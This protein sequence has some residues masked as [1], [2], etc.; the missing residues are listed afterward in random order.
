MTLEK[1]RT[2]VGS[3]FV[4]LSSIKKTLLLSVLV[5]EFWTSRLGHKAKDEWPADS[6]PSWLNSST[7]ATT[8]ETRLSSSDASGSLSVPNR[9]KWWRWN[10]RPHCSPVLWLMGQ[11]CVHCQEKDA[12][13]CVTAARTNIYLH[14]LALVSLSP[15][16]LSSLTDSFCMFSYSLVVSLLN[17]KFCT[18]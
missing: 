7:A 17:T 18:L 13:G 14:L 11:W 1:T 6:S 10:Q 12:A 15:R 16:K 8:T 2:A 9:L 4:F 5:E 3:V